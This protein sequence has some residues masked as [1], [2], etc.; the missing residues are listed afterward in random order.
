M[1]FKLNFYVLCVR[2]FNKM[3]KKKK[4]KNCSKNVT[5]MFFVMIKLTYFVKI[6]LVKKM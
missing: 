3:S 6:S 2:Y 5:T 1:L 4:D